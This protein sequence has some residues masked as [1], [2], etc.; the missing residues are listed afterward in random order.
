[1]RW[2][3]KALTT[4]PKLKIEIL[5]VVSCKIKDKY[6]DQLRHLITPNQFAEEYVEIYIP[7]RSGALQTKRREVKEL[8]KIKKQRW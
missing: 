8:K 7:K 6:Y 3:Y 4:P 1:L 2:I 5:L